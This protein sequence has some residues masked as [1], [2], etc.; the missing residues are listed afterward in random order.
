MISTLFGRI[1]RTSCSGFD[2]I[3]DDHRVHSVEDLYDGLYDY[4]LVGKVSCQIMNDSQCCCS[5][6][7]ERM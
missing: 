5:Y 3:V 7:P 1:S 4:Y 2:V 6:F